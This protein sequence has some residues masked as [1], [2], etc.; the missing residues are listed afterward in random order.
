MVLQDNVQSGVVFAVGGGVKQEA[1]PTKQ[2]QT[3]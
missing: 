1:H 3:I 2:H